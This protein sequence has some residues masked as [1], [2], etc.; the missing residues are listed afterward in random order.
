MGRRKKGQI[1][2]GW[3]NLNK[4]KGV[5]STRA[6]NIV[7]RALDARKAGHGGTLDPLADGILPIA[8]GEATKTVAF[9]Q[10]ALKTY[11]F[12]ITWGQERD[13]D[14]EEGQILYKSDKRPS[15]DSIL[16][17]IPS[18]TGDIDQIPPQ[19]SAIKIDGKRAYDLARAGEKVEIATRPIYIETLDLIEQTKDTATLRCVCGKGT[20]IRAIARDMGREL[21]C[22]GYI[23]NLKRESVGPFSLKNAI[24]LDFFENFDH[25][26]TAST[27]EDNFLLPIQSM[28]DDIP[29]LCLTDQE[30]LKL[31]QGQKLTFISRPDMGRIKQSGID[32]EDQTEPAEALALH[33]DKAIALVEVDGVEIYPLR[34][35]NL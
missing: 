28:L 22:Y 11:L 29:A 2:N 5:E 23:S 12:T 34:V 21:G 31:K 3:I 16:E 14:D 6:V 20:Y 33:N 9:A 7:R 25:S 27:I 13:T 30:A 15:K 1:I 18:F 26:A 35:F 19:F 32:I 17:C 8:L 10:D 4:P 24:S